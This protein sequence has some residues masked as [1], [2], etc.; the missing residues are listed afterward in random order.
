LRSA[1]KGGTYGKVAAHRLHAITSF[2]EMEPDVGE[3]FEEIDEFFHKKDNITE[4]DI[5]EAAVR[6]MLHSKI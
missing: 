5:E 6:V 1:L 3:L 2:Y 4:K